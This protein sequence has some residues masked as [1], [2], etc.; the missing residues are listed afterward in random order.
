M[1]DIGGTVR[2]QFPLMLGLGR[3]RGVTPT[4]RY[5]DLGGLIVSQICNLIY[6]T[7]DLFLGFERLAKRGRATLPYFFPRHEPLLSRLFRR[8]IAPFCSP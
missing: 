2:R 3:R 5:C 4:V 8:P 1:D 6:N 7:R